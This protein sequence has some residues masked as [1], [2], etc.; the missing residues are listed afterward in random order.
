[1]NIVHC[2]T[3]CALRK[4]RVPDASEEVWYHHGQNNCLLEQPLS[5]RQPRYVDPMNVWVTGDNISI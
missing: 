4:L 2:T 3:I 5:V 1:M